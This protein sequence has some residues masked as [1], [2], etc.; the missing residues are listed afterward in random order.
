MK[1]MV[2][3]I[4]TASVLT[5]IVG[6]IAGVSV[7]TSPQP[8]SAAPLFS[9]VPAGGYPDAFPYGQ[10][11]WWVAYNRRV[12]WGGDARDWLGNARAR[13]VPT[14]RLPSLGGIVVYRSGGGYSDLGHVAIVIATAP[15]S[16]SVSEM[17]F[18]GWGQVSTRTVA[19]PDPQVEGF[20]PLREGEG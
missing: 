9:W 11:T 5:A 6:S 10:C 12:T 13:G 15:G 20:I 18:I 8:S 2:A 7:A 16:Y 4:L 19:W 14:S 17:N 3:A 1:F